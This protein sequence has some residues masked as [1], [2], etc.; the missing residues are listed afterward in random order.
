MS[1]PT[2]QVN[3]VIAPFVDETLTLVPNACRA[4]FLRCLR[5]EKQIYE[6]LAD[7]NTTATQRRTQLIRHHRDGLAAWS[8]A[9]RHDLG[10]ETILRIHTL[11]REIDQ[12]LRRLYQPQVRAQ[13]WAMW[14]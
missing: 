4:A 7:P 6:L 14:R 5:H 13:L 2:S 11:R 3:E 9:E 10:R 12:A 8:V 1:I